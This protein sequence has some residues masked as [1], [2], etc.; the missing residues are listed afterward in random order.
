M[1][2]IPT[3]LRERVPP[4]TA[5]R[6]PGG[7][8]RTVLKL[9][10][11]GHP[12]ELARPPEG[13]GLKPVSGDFGLPIVGHTL[14]QMRF[15]VRF[16]L[17]RYERYGPVSW[18]GAFGTRI[19]GFSGP[20]ATQAVLT[21]KDKVFSQ[22]GWAELIDN[23][24]HRG[25]MLLDFDEHM[26]HRRIMQEAFTRDR[27]AGYVEQFTP[28]LRE[29]I[30]QW[31]TDRPPRLYWH[32]K[33]LTLNVASRVFMGEQ[34]GESA[35]RLN[36][37]FVGT[38]RAPTSIVRVPVPGGR[39][40]SGIKGRRMLERYFAENL[41]AKRAGDGDDL[42][43]A[44]CHAVTREGDSFG[45]D[46]VINH[47]IF[48]MMA[49]HDTATIT[50][51]AAAYYLAKHPSWQRRARQ[52][53]LAAGDDPLDMAA[54]ERL[55]TLDLVIKEALRLVAPVPSMMR[56]TVADTEVAGHYIP[57]NTLCVASPLIN[58]F[59]EECWSNPHEFDPERFDTHRR[60]DKSHRFAWIP[61]GGGAH[62]CIGMAFGMLEVKALLHEMLRNYEWSVPADY[63]ARWDHV[64]LPVPA[65]GL[66]IHLT[67]R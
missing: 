14:E 2:G 58:H 51:S 50:S 17:R 39:W 9:S 64:S 33:R 63:E 6:L 38:V 66:P 54:L 5:V 56:K 47:M 49:A 27:L 48:L 1:S 28:V 7:I 55:H 31:P 34:A 21:N 3:T 11:R 16:A 19:V 52:E 59:V 45:D 61:F 35:D 46:D 57:A 32:L 60:E 65:D 36:R 8:D 41:P 67:R 40:R 20:E 44:L 26:A 10:E 62:K 29:Q 25:L 12:R 13:S 42:F 24:F 30:T 4:V 43:S 18:S 22:Q 15:G 23:F 53:S 37:A